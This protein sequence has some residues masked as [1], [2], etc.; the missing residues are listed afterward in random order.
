MSY[1]HRQAGF[2]VARVML[3]YGMALGTR[4]LF[5][6]EP[7]PPPDE[8]VDKLGIRYKGKALVERLTQDPRGAGNVSSHFT[9]RS[10]EAFRRSGMVKLD[11]ETIGEVMVDWKRKASKHRRKLLQESLG[12]RY[13][14]VTKTYY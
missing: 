1:E 11:N 13:D 6:L 5:E 14:P 2:A 12:M 3:V 10:T 7:K 9:P 4:S 8:A